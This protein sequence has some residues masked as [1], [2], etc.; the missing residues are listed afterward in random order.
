MSWM[1]SRTT[2]V[3]AVLSFGQ[4]RLYANY[5]INN[6]HIVAAI[7]V[8]SDGAHRGQARSYRMA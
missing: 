8:S 2:F 1:N 7:D 5:Q 3:E 6:A 4:Y